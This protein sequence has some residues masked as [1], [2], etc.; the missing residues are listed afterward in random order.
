[1]R[2]PPSRRW[3]VELLPFGGPDTPVIN[4]KR[5][6]SLTTRPPCLIAGEVLHGAY[7]ALRGCLQE[8]AAGGDAYAELLERLSGALAEL[9][10]CELS[11]S[12]HETKLCFWLNCFNAGV[13]VALRTADTQLLGAP[14]STLGAW[15]AFLRASQLDVQGNLFSLLDIEHL[16]LRAHSSPPQLPSRGGS[17][18]AMKRLLRSL[19]TR[20]EDDRRTHLFLTQPA[21]EVTFGIHYPIACGAPPLRVYQP[22]LVG[23]QLLV[24]C[25][26]YVA[27][28]MQVDP[29]WRRATLPG[30]YRWYWA[31]F[32]SSDAGVLEHV[33]GVLRA[34]PS[35]LRELR[36]APGAASAAD[37]ALASDVGRLAEELEALRKP[38][39][40]TGAEAFAGVRVDYTEVDWAFDFLGSARVV[41][42][43][44][45]AAEL[46]P[47]WE[48]SE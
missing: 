38:R 39:A 29:R 42:P 33:R 4:R 13:L 30:L 3:E 7:L 40:A 14:P 10:R 21:P 32:G 1:L 20:S 9:Q 6:C 8:A 18:T 12:D 11:G 45:A 19:P 22:E 24:N 26:H 43:L 37:L 36:E 41:C 17:P 2:T 28:S 15:I 35:R 44:L 5:F 31:D 27:Q 16:V 46:P 48:A 25:A 23:A 34:A 47:P